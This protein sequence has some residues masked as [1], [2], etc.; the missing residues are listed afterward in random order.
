MWG[1]S[2]LHNESLFHTYTKVE[3]VSKHHHKETSKLSHIQTTKTHND[4]NGISL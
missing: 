4:N 3:N 2:G 1:H